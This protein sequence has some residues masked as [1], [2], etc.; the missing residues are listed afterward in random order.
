MFNSQI[1]HLHKQCGC[2]DPPAGPCYFSEDWDPPPIRMH[3][4][5]AGPFDRSQS[6]NWLLLNIEGNTQIKIQPVPTDLDKFQYMYIQLY[7]QCIKRQKE[8]QV[9]TLHF[10]RVGICESVCIHCMEMCCPLQIWVGAINS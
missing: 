9:G 6:N 5:P 10:C 4:L 3:I 8:K 1:L 2:R 7:W